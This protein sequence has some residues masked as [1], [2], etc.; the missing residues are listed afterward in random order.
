MA[1][2][3]EDSTAEGSTARH[4]GAGQRVGGG[5]GTATAC[6]DLWPGA[7]SVCAAI[8]RALAGMLAVATG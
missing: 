4:K 2:A 3:A 7:W 6:S 1:L 8:A 5:R